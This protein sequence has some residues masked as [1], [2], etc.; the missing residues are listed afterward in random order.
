MRHPRQNLEDKFLCKGNNHPI[1]H[2]QQ[3]Q[4]MR[5][6]T[7]VGQK[8]LKKIINHAG[9]VL[10]N[11]ASCKSYVTVG[12]EKNKAQRKQLLICKLEYTNTFTNLLSLA[13][14]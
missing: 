5:I 14:E 2:G 10:K 9:K 3:H 1:F 4:T 6:Q 8:C 11:Q 7:Q 13:M 12:A